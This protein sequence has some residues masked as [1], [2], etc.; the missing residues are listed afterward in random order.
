MNG[1]STRQGR[2]V[3]L[4]A[5]AVFACVL[6]L[7]YP[8]P[9][10]PTPTGGPIVL[11]PVMFDGV[12]ARLQAGGDYYDVV[13]DALRANGYPVRSVF[14]WRTP[15]LWTAL[16]P[17]AP[18]VRRL[19]LTLLGAV[20]GTIA[21]LT[22]RRRSR[23]AAAATATTMLGVALLMSAPAA[24]AMG[25]AWAGA[26]VGLSVCAYTVERRRWGA[27]LGLLA[28]FVRELVAPY[29]VICTILAWRRRHRRELAGWIVG[30]FTYMAYFA[31]HA[32]QVRAHQLPTDLAYT[33]SWVAIGGVPFLLSTVRWNGLLLLSAP[34]FTV[35]AFALIATAVAAPAV[36]VHLRLTT[37]AYLTLFLFV[38]G[39]FNRYWGYLTWPTW[40]LACGHAADGLR[41]AW[42]DLAAP[43]VS[44]PARDD[45]PAGRN[46]PRR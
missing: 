21:V 22:A 4:L 27:A 18:S 1:P 26:L 36:P 25:E 39:E 40:M 34:I 15:L 13:G 24:V 8:A 37:C 45:P 30:G 12:L 44:G 33:H 35:V 42:L 5:V 31:V 29:A 23:F 11:D 28:M 2:A 16:A 9:P 17:L 43:G 41:Q 46:A 10:L 19:L 38:G 6:G 32:S 7:Q 14:N 3:L 20:V